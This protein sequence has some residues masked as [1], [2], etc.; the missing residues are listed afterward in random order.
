MATADI[1][2]TEEDYDLRKAWDNAC[3]SFVSTTK[4]DLIGG[5]ARKPEDVIARLT[6]Q[7]S[8]GDI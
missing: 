2:F 6:L 1:T 3:R 5:D 4:C 7:N 8:L